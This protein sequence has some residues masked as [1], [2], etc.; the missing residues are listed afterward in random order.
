MPPGELKTEALDADIPIEAL[1]DGV[2][3]LAEAEARAEIARARAVALREQA[4]RAATGSGNPPDEE[5][6][7]WARRFRPRRPGRR[8]LAVIAAI[9]VSCGA[10]AG[11]GYLIW[12]HQRVVQQTQRTA[13]FAAVARNAVQIM[14][15]V[16]STKARADMQRFADETTGQF[17]AGVLMG[18]EDMVR[19][20]EESKVVTKASVQSV[21][22]QSMTS[23]SAVVLVAARSEITKP[24]QSKPEIRTWRLVVNVATDAGRLK[25]AKVEFVP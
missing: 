3:D 20:L 6:R 10:L 4:E 1:L 14:M 8:T 19:S 22:V 24:D 12:H 18:A 23:D 21:A 9:L 7:S 25:I 17:K 11:S 13:E 2:D 15:S 5:R 16:D